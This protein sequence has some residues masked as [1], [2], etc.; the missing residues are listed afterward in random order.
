MD[1]AAAPALV[2]YDPFS[3]KVDGPMWTLDAFV[4]LA[5]Q[6]ANVQARTPGAGPTELLTYTASTAI[7]TSMLLAGFTV[8]VGPSTGSKRE[9]TF[10]LLGGAP[11]QIAALRGDRS[12]L[13]HA[14]LAR[15]ARSTRQFSDD[16]AAEGRAGLE[17]RLHALPQF[18]GADAAFVLP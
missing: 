17:A 15:R 16:V 13:D 3:A 1:A 7:R 8:G 12:L 11:D 6:L 5:A 4:R 2:L 18:T 9:T 10:A 14:W